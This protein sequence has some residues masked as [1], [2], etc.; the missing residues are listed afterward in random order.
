[1]YDWLYYFCGE[2]E[3]W[4]LV[5]WFNHTSWVTAVTPTDRPKS[6]RNSCVI[7]VFG[8]VFMLSCCFLDYSVGVGVFV[9]GLSQIS[10]FFSFDYTAR[11]KSVRN[12]CVI[13][14]FG[15]VFMLSRGLLDFSVGVGDFVIGLSQISSN[16]FTSPHLKEDTKWASLL[17]KRGI[18]LHLRFL[19][20]LP[21]SESLLSTNCFPDPPFIKILWYSENG[22]WFSRRKYLRNPTH[23][24]TLTVYYN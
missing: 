19:L 13:K 15:G 4:A 23:F 1:M 11:P 10:S 9:T 21:L 2:W 22:K 8:G 16:H 17:S 5:N 3:G 6:I 24:Q 18:Y 7:K 12:R 20:V 14:V